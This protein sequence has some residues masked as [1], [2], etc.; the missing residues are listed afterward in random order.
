MLDGTFGLQ[1]KFNSGEFKKYSSRFGSNFIGGVSQS[2]KEKSVT[3]S[4]TLLEVGGLKN[5][6]LNGLSLSFLDYA[7]DKARRNESPQAKITLE[8]QTLFFVYFE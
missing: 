2:L 4:G 7:Q 8:D 5:A 3:N 6:I 1:G